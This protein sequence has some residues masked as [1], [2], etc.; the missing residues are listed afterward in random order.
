VADSDPSVVTL[1]PKA[2]DATGAMRARRFRKRK[3]RAA[4]TPPVTPA[5]T[6][7][8]PNGAVRKQGKRNNIKA[9]ATVAQATN[10]R[11][12]GASDVA[13]YGAAIGL[14]RYVAAGLLSA[15]GIG[16][17]TIGMVETASYSLAVGGFLFC[18]LAMSAD[19]LTLVMPAT[20]GALW[21]KRSPAVAL[22]GLLWGAGVAVTVVN[23]AGY[24]GE[25]IEQ[26]QAA[27][28][29]KAT[30]RSVAM[31]RLAW[32]RDERKAI[33]ETRPPAAILAVMAGARRSEQ[34]QLREALAMARRRDALDLELAAFEKRLAEIPQVATAD[35]SAAV[36]SEIGG[37]AISEVE[38]RQFRLALLLGLPLCGGLV[39]SLAF[40]LATAATST[41]PALIR[42]NGFANEKAAG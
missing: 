14:G 2:K 28:E 19:L 37:T 29:T 25:H 22:A 36:L 31:E 4:V 7:A 11:R 17:S 6:L 5:V 35:A 24:V 21:R 39:L 12:P 41:R 9:D 42:A 23:I 33:N 34:P 8:A 27:R 18:A 13:P 38:L 10:E 30:E 16:L 20:I 26:Y 15:V 3:A 1:H 32:L 40:A